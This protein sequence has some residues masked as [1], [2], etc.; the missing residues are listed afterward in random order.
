MKRGIRVLLS[1][2]LA[3]APSISGANTL[4]AGKD[5]KKQKRPT[6]ACRLSGEAARHVKRS[7]RKI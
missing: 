1:L 5:T 7:V 6:S 4:P 2:L 3:A